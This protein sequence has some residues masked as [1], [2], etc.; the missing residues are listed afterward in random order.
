[1]YIFTPSR[2]R[3]AAVT[4]C[5]QVDVDINVFTS[6][7]MVMHKHLTICF[8]CCTLTL[9]VNLCSGEFQCAHTLL[10]MVCQM[11]PQLSLV[12]DVTNCQLSQTAHGGR[13]FTS[14]E[15]EAFFPLCFAVVVFTAVLDEAR[16]KRQKQKED[17]NTYVCV[18][19]S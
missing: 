8:I 13:H 2:H 18:G 6:W 10:R 9:F 4:H 19:A 17:T 3:N 14:M 16:N 12:L 1:M 15:G 5:K 7:R 11:H